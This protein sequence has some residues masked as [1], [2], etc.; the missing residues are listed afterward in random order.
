[1]NI[2]RKLFT[3]VLVA[4]LISGCQKYY[5]MIP[6]PQ[7]TY[8]SLDDEDLGVS[9]QGDKIFVSVYGD[10]DMDGSSW[11]NAYDVAGLRTILT[12]KS[13]LS[14][15]V[16]CLMEGKYIVGRDSGSGLELKKNIKQ[17]KG[18]YSSSSTGSDISKCNPQQYE[19]VLSG[20][21]N[22][23]GKADAGDCAMFMVTGGSIAFEGVVFEGGYIDTD[24]SAINS[25]QGSDGN[26]TG[27]AAVFGIFGNPLSTVVELRDCV[28]RKNVSAATHNGSAQG[29]TSIAGG[30]CAIVTSGFLMARGCS[31]ENNVAVNRGGAIRLMG[32]DAACFLDKCVFTGNSFSGTSDGWGSSIQ[33]SYGHLC[34]NNTTFIHNHGKGGEINGGGAFLLVNSSLFQTDEDTF[35]AFRCESSSGASTRFVNSLFSSM[36]ADGV[37][38]NYSGD[39]RDITSAGF[40]IFQRVRGKEIHRADDVLWPDV[41][42]GYLE[43]GCWIWD[44][45]QVGSNADEVYAT[46]TDVL[47]AVKSFNPT[48]SSES[49][50]V[51]LGV[52]FHDWVGESGFSE[53]Q[54][55]RP[56]NPL[57]MQKGSYDAYLDGGTQ[58]QLR[59]SKALVDARTL[60]VESFG[61]K[62]NNA[63]NPTYSYSTT[64]VWDGVKWNSTE[65]INMMW[66]PDMNPVDIMAVSPAMDMEGTVPVAAGCDLLLAK[67]KVYPETDLTDGGVVL[68]F[69]HLMSRLVIEMSNIEATAINDVRVGGTILSGKCDFSKE[70]PA[71]TPDGDAAGVIVVQKANDDYQAF[72]VP[73][74]TPSVLNVSFTDNDGV[75]YEW[76]S[77]LPVTFDAGKSYTLTLTASTTKSGPR[78]VHG[79]IL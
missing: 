29:K 67:T 46:Q 57:K 15:A 62:I 54:R 18:G 6:P 5:M 12:D 22:L 34:V 30:P 8:D 77:E 36:R 2:M 38:F 63:A 64:M 71:V 53:D 10:G 74:T 14:N 4:I 52:R 41:L 40:N 26:S 9:S 65:G 79:T 33:V 60:G 73:Q 43:N 35:G 20:D 59:I 78:S 32:D 16:I 44:A 50:F 13:D 24:I 68:H 23:N 17:I 1:M 70:S 39:D 75:T 21:V 51:N 48:I 7:S 47:N 66:D 31:F 37:G 58:K 49:A 72:L 27:A 42:S 76:Q 45:S 61:I 19:S 11:D 25:V 69:S 28:L 56:R 55:G 3:M